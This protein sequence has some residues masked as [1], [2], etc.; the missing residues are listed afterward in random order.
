MI[1]TTGFLFLLV[2]SGVWSLTR[3]V[4]HPAS[5]YILVWFLILCLSSISII[6]YPD[7][8]NLT[9]FIIILSAITFSISSIVGS[10]IL[11]V[12]GA[13]IINR[14]QASK[15]MPNIFTLASL[16]FLGVGA[17]LYYYQSRF[18][19][20]VLLNN[21][22]YVRFTDREGSGFY[23]ILLLL[24]SFS[25]VAVILRWLISREKS[26]FTAF[27][28]IFAYAY[29]AILPERTTVIANTLWIIGMWIVLDK[30]F[31]KKISKYFVVAVLSLVAIVGFFVIVNNRTGKNEFFDSIGY[32]IKNTEMPKAL[33]S[34]YI[35][36]TGSISALSSL[37]SSP[38]IQN[39]DIKLDRTMFPA[40][41][42][43]QLISPTDGSKLSEA[44]DAAFIPFYFNTYTWL[45]LPIRD[46]GIIGSQF[47]ILICGLLCG[48][49]YRRAKITHRPLWT[50]LY[51]GV[52]S[53]VL[54]SGMTNRFSSL[55]WWVAAAFAVLILSR[56]K[57]GKRKDRFHETFTTKNSLINVQQS[58]T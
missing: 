22:G 50:F 8:S 37:I 11:R 21:P 54:L 27:I 4:R 26:W 42:V 23:G 56:P 52:F 41:R 16:V 58:K 40:A 47:Y 39:F 43:L 13:D 33:I 9:L 36:A 55:T 20:T 10:S 12:H 48:L 38:D 7:V 49:I 29:F 30:K 45:S 19:L 5:L 53:A 3:D 1:G 24:P 46:Q 51:G 17:G 6:K 57:I 44:E 32:A 28:V 2:G 18:G 25:V 14:D 31:Y 15:Y 35:Y 34:P